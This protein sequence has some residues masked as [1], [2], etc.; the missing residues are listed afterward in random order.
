MNINTGALP[1]IERLNFIRKSVQFWN[2]LEDKK[3]RGCYRMMGREKYSLEKQGLMIHIICP[4]CRT[5]ACMMTNGT[6]SLGF[7]NEVAADRSI[8][9]TSKLY[10]DILSAKIKS[11]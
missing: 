2:L 3:K 9:M 6:G 8:K 1:Q 11:N 10:R 4:T 7:I 5:W